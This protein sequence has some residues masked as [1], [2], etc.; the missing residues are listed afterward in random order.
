MLAYYIV[1]IGIEV[2]LCGVLSNYDISCSIFCVVV[3]G[4][5]RK[6]GIFSSMEECY[7][8]RWYFYMH[9]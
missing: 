2:L 5:I 3:I 6:L 8:K 7:V 4:S 9:V 1:V